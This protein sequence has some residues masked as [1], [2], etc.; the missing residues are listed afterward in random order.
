MRYSSVAVLDH[1]HNFTWMTRTLLCLRCFCFPCTLVLITLLTEA[2]LMRTSR[3]LFFGQYSVPIT[4]F[5]EALLL[6]HLAFVTSV[7]L[8]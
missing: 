4:L 6:P 8:I 7:I 3:T 1:Y 2:A 5:E